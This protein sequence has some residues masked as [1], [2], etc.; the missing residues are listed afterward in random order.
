[1]RR[2]G[3]VPGKPFDPD[4][5]DPAT[6]AGV[7][8]AEK[9]G[10]FVIDLVRRGRGVRTATGWTANRAS[11][12]VDFDYSTRA[13]NA[14]VGLMGNDPEEALYF[15]NFFDSEGQALHGGMAKDY[16]N[17][18]NQAKEAQAAG[19]MAECQASADR[20]KTIYN[21]ARGK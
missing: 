5:L 18:L 12:T 4:S 21:K 14:L 10:P 11:N 9:D 13:G 7:L 15:N 3:L 17:L 2:I 8:R 1:M 19:N 16:Q 20:A 6:R